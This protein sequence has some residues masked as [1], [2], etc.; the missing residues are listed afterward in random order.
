ME[1]IEWV[2]G[3]A[4]FSPTTIDAVTMGDQ[5]EQ[6]AAWGN[7]LAED[8][9]SHDWT[10][11]MTQ[12]ALNG[13]ARSSADFTREGTPLEWRESRAEHLVLGLDSSV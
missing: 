8:I 3:A 6:Y 11:A 4:G 10:P 13:L 1:A 12:K 2:L 9:S 5:E 7:Q